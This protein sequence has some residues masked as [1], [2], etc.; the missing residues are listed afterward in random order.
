MKKL[1]CSCFSAR[2]LLSS[3]ITIVVNSPQL[4]PSEI[5]SASAVLNG[6]AVLVYTSVNFRKGSKGTPLLP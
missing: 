3:I 4:D 1:L 5:L 2:E 6:N